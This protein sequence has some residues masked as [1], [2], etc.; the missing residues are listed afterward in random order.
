MAASLRKECL[1]YQGSRRSPGCENLWIAGML[2]DSL[3]DCIL[4]ER[5]D[6]GQKISSNMKLKRVHIILG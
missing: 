2:R 4:K 3:I 5:Y 6:A 1:A